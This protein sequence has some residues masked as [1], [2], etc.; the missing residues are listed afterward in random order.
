[1]TRAAFAAVRAARLAALVLVALAAP[2][3]ARDASA[4]DP[5]KIRSVTPASA[6]RGSTVDVAIE[7]TSLYPVEDVVVGAQDIG[8]ALQPGN[9]ERR[10]VV[11]LTIPDSAQPGPVSITV[12]TKDGTVRT[13]RF[14][15]RMRIPTV[16]RAVP[17]ALHRGATVDVTLT[18]TLLAFPGYDTKVTTDGG[19]KADVGA[20][21]TATTL[22]LKVVVPM[23]APAGPHAFSVE[24]TDGKVAVPFTVLLSPPTLASVTPATIARGASV[25]LALA[26]TN[27]VG[28]SPISLAVPD[29][30]LRL[31]PAGE[32]TMTATSVKATAARDA[33]IGPRLLVLQTPDGVATIPLEVVGTPPRALTVTP[34]AA[35]RG[36][37]VEV[38]LGGEAVPADADWRFVPDDPAVRLERTPGGTRKVVVAPDARPGPRTLVCV[39]PDGAATTVFRVGL[40]P[41]AVAGVA[42]AEVAPGS[43]ATLVVEGQNLEGATLSLAEGEG[44]E[45]EAS[46]GGKGGLHVKVAAGAR[47]GPRAVLVRG[48]DGSAIGRFTVTGPA[49]AAP[50]LGGATPGRILRGRTTTVVLAGLNLEPPAGGAPTVVVRGA[51][52]APLPVK[53]TSASA[54]RLALEVSPPAGAALGGGVVVVKTPEGA[55][56]V[57][58]S[59]D[60]ATP[61]I[62]A[63]TP[64]TFSRPGDVEVALE[65]AGLEGPGGA[66]PRVSL[67]PAG[68]RSRGRG[69]GRD[70]HARARH[71]E[72]DASAG[73]ADRG[74]ARRARYGRGRRR[75]GGERR[76]RRAV[77]RRRRSQEPRRPRGRRGVRHGEAPPRARREAPEGRGD[78]RRLVLYRRGARVE[79]RRGRA[80]RDGAHAR[81]RA[82]GAAP[83]RR[84]DG[85]RLGG[86]RDRGGGRT[87][88]RGR[89]DR[90]GRGRAHGERHDDDP[91]DRPCG[92]DGG[93]LRGTGRQGDD[94]PGRRR[95]GALVRI[96]VAA[97]AAVGARAFL[98]VTPGGVSRRRRKGAFSVP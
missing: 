3:L 72:G 40:R 82:G 61:S 34:S 86:G 52:D 57:A 7:G 11:R 41:P 31:E 97:D 5:P 23:T 83:A 87:A 14:S 54:N 19:I 60:P 8:S 21:S 49:A 24:T 73:R 68:R 33:A 77:D 42:P 27:L 43:E 84:Q 62:E 96:S 85:G 45:A 2:G 4:G 81:G 93:G 69:G 15:V 18:G 30:G 75:G 51:D 74:L 80:G 29:S 50:S 89:G 67:V 63:A 53:V 47:P 13:D 92:G 37:T 90:P 58:L 25:A 35:D 76:V 6:P 79:G 98:V 10:L 71:R 55:A 26:G 95:Q 44:V 64:A 36:A 17:A 1:M 28:A 59:V 78:A 66:A 38:T 12:K 39:T 88:A 32:T 70:A 48:P 20:K 16:T 94:P 91:R 22:L 65:G 56:A 46:A 9:G